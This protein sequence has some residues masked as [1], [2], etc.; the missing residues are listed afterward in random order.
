MSSHCPRLPLTRNTA[1]TVG[2]VL[3]GFVT[4][5]KKIGTNLV[6]RDAKPEC[7]S[8]EWRG[9]LVPGIAA[10]LLLPLVVK[11][12]PQHSCPWGIIDAQ[13]R[14]IVWLDK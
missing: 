5:P 11:W 3:R 6:S 12:G 4:F 9:C 8:K 13:S 14:A 1:F 7:A 10:L 2:I